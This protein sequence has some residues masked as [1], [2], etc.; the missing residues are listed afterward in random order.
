LPYDDSYLT[1][2]GDNLADAGTKAFFFD[3]DDE[4]WGA[5]NDFYIDEVLLMVASDSDFMNA[6]G[7]GVSIDI[8]ITSD[9]N[10][11]F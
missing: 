10:L 3:K 2:G 6:E 11:L 4:G 8:Y 9:Q 5:D 7:E 1:Y